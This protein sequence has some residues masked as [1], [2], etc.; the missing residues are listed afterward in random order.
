MRAVALQGYF[1]QTGV[2]GYSSALARHTLS[3]LKPV[4]GDKVRREVVDAAKCGAC[5]EWFEGHGGNRVI[6]LGTQ[7]PVVC[8]A[9]HV[10]NLT[11][12]GRGAD[13]A[14]VIARLKTAGANTPLIWDLNAN[15]VC[16]AAEDANADTFCDVLD[17][18]LLA[19]YDP[20][21]PLTFPEVTNDLKELVHA[22]HG[23]EARETP[24]R[25]VRDRGS[26]GVFYY[27]FSFVT[28]PNT[29]DACL[30]CHK[31]GT[32]SGVPDGA[33]MTNWRTSNGVDDRTNILAARNTVPNAMDT[34]ATP[35][36]SA[37]WACHDSALAKAHMEQNGAFIGDLRMNSHTGSETCA[38]C[39]GPGRIADI[40]VVHGL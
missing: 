21:D 33:A 15:G 14:T 25:E 29:K 39:H 34:V 35:F 7:G 3:V 1:S 11:T 22:I 18:M 38:L 36:A 23:A 32:Y 28:Y 17:G 19:G 20:A 9:C 27:D 13:P 26:S 40:Q 24:F 4:S 6:G 5:H 12:S 31:P 2:P 16:D 10:P 8:A 37:C 30:A